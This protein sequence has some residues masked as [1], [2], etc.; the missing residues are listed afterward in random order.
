[1][2]EERPPENVLESLSPSLSPNGWFWLICGDRI[3]AVQ[4]EEEQEQQAKRNATTS[5]KYNLVDV[6]IGFELLSN[7]SSF[8]VWTGQA[9]RRAGG[10]VDDD[11]CG[12]L[13]QL[14]FICHRAAS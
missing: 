7:Y 8:R 4:E 2:N 13:V 3:A 5:V 11:D 9:E 10:D 12:L 14:R 6:E 1:M